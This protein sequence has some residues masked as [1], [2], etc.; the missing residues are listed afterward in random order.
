MLEQSTALEELSWIAI[1]K[2][3]IEL[4]RVNLVLLSATIISEY[5]V[6]VGDIKLCKQD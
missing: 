5:S 4:L 3:K 1:S 6:E 2:Q